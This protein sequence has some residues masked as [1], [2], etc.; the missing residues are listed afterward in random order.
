MIP[1]NEASVQRLLPISEATLSWREQLQ[2]MLTDLDQLQ[3]YLGLNHPPAALD[4]QAP[5]P[6]R[7]TRCFADLMEPG[8]WHDPL[9][10]QVLPWGSERDLTP[11]FSNDPLAEALATPSPGLIHKYAHRVLVLPTSVCAIHCRYCFR[12]HFPYAEHRLSSDDKAALIDYLRAHPDINEVILSGGDPLMLK[13]EQLAD[14]VQALAALPQITRIRVHSRLPIVLPDRLTDTLL[15]TL[16]QSRLKVVLVLHANHPREVSDRLKTQLQRWQY[17]S[18][19]LLNQS[20]LLAGVNDDAQTLAELSEALFST[21]VLPYYL[22]VLDRVQGTAH[23][24]VDERQA[25]HIHQE[26]QRL[27]PGFLVPK[28]VREEPGKT[29]KTWLIA[30]E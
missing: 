9:L 29:G 17:S 23:F 12:R 6:V 18:V 28:L 27:C 30:A 20:V 7:V 25:Q 5:F 16:T 26:L 24:E 13:D 21:G 4:T 14:W 3:Q 11:G 15:K 2:Q 19:T 8:N 22:H 1:E 10:R